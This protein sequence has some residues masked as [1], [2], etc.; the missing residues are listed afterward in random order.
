MPREDLPVLVLVEGPG[1]ASSRSASRRG[2]PASRRACARSS[3]SGVLPHSSPRS[4][5]SR[6][7]GAPIASAQLADHVERRGLT[8]ERWLAVH[9]DVESDGE[10]AQYFMPLAI[11]FEDG[12]E[13]RWRKLQPAAIARVRQQA[14]V[15]VLADAC[16]DEN[17]CRAPW[18]MRSAL[19]A[20]SPTESR[21]VRA[22]RPPPPTRSCA[23]IRPPISPRARRPP[24]A[25]TRRCGC[26]DQLF[27]KIYR[28]CSPA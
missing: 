17:F 18:S 22:S 25:A 15:G 20:S 6:G 9:F 23:A 14:T 26:G 3:R 1:T 4:A 12:E 24:R 21:H 27:L 10:P 28:R 13:A 5:G 7:K 11:A 8:L 2:A 19:G 16:G